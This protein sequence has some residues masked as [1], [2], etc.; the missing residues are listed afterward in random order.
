M[1]SPSWNKCIHPQADNHIDAPDSKQ[2]ANLSDSDGDGLPA[3]ALHPVKCCAFKAGRHDNAAI[4][5]AHGRVRQ[6]VDAR[7]RQ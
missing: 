6:H 3:H 1:R 7:R 4:A 5:G 2:C